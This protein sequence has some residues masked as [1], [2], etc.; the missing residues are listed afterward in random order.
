MTTTSK[1]MSFTANETY[2]EYKHQLTID[3]L[4]N[5]NHE[6]YSTVLLRENGDGN[7]QSAPNNSYWHGGQ[8]D[9]TAYIGGDAK[10]NNISPCITVFIWKRVK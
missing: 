6:A 1:C 7:I 5:H 3:E 9:N 2:G 4:P 10:H 8:K